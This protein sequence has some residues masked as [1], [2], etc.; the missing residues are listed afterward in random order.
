MLRLFMLSALT[1][2]FFSCGGSD[3]VEV[4]NKTTM[5]LDT[6]VFDAGEV[7][8]GEMITAVFNVTNTGSHPLYIAQVN[9]SCSCTVADRP[10]GPIPPG[11]TREIIAH[12]NTDR[13]GT[14]ILNKT[15]RITANTTPSITQVRI[16]GNVIQK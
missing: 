3:T 5:K 9:A 14:G 16:T 7:M 13:T 12:V 6:I 2:L 10:E 8:K 15:L 1:F 4:G 11:E